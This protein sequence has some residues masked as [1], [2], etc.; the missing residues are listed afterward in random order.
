MRDITSRERAGAGLKKQS[1]ADLYP[2]VMISVMIST[3]VRC[4]IQNYAIRL[5]TKRD[6]ESFLF[7]IIGVC[8]CVCVCV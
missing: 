3:Q 8:V 2:E 7:N 5:M 1:R 6:F 4:E